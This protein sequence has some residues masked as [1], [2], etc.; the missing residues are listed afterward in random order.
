MLLK[1][2]MPFICVSADIR[3]LIRDGRSMFNVM[4]A[5]GM[6]RSHSCRGNCG[7]T[8]HRHAIKWSFNVWMAL[9][10]AL[11]LCTWGGAN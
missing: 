8:L 4:H 3:G 11:V 6:R 7:W 2:C 5:C 9:S 1:L 10:A